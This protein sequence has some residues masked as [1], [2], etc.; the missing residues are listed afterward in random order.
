M[1]TVMSTFHSFNDVEYY[2]DKPLANWQSVAIYSE[3]TDEITAVF[4]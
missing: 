4:L 2:E 1:S 3:I